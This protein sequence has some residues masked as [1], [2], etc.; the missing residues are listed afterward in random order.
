MSE[1]GFV[2]GEELSGRYVLETK[3]GEGAAGWVWRA[4]DKK[5]GLHVAMKLLRPEI[6][7]Q[8]GMFARFA[9]ESDV[10]RRML[11]PNVVKVLD[12]GLTEDG[13]PYIVY[14]DLDGEDLA[15][16]IKRRGRLPLSEMSTI[17][18]HVCRGLARAH[19]LGVIHCD[20]KPDNTFLTK[21][22]HGNM[23][24]KLL[25]FGV[26]ELTAKHGEGDSSLV[27]TLEY[28][29]PEV[30]LGAN[31]PSPQSD[32]YSVGVL[33]YECIT[34]RVP[35]PAD[36]VH[37]LVMALATKTY[38]TAGSLRR[39]VTND[40]DAWFA[41]ALCDDPDGRFPSAKAMAEALQAAMSTVSERSLETAEFN[42]RMP[43][44]WSSGGSARAGTSYSIVPGGKDKDD[45]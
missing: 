42:P 20:V 17:V 8:P 26:A 28:I 38:P 18:I 23:L 36:S 10:S 3:L 15:A 13:A 24:A 27:G 6:V 30:F 45:E 19:A 40:L 33:A 11:S 7:D 14:E 1:N 32:L 35:R 43:S 29:A 44:F 16:K 25:D 21:D 2:V 39:E 12:G 4:K 5:L 37:E 34:G 22:T 9:R 31:K 41:R